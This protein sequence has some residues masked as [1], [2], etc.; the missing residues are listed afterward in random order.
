VLG[1]RADQRGLAHP[2]RAGEADDGGVAGMRVDLPHEL[3]ALRAV[4]LDQ[5]DRAGERTAV[6]RE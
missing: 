3:P 4:V 1:D 2:G 6:T 5:R